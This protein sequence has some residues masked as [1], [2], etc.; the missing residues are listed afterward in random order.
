MAINLKSFAC[1]GENNIA[2]QC[3]KKNEDKGE[4]KRGTA[5]VA[6]RELIT[7]CA[8]GDVPRKWCVDAT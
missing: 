8:R 7:L 4:M 6:K 5:S 2:F 3:P 1:G